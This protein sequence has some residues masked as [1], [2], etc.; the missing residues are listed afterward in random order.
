MKVYPHIPVE[1]YIRQNGSVCLMFLKGRNECIEAVFNGLYNHGMTHNGYSSSPIELD[2][3][4][5][6]ENESMASF[7]STPE[8]IKTFFSSL[9]FH[10]IIGDGSKWKGKKGGIQKECDTYAE[11]QYKLLCEN[12]ALPFNLTSRYSSHIYGE[13]TTTAERPDHDFKD[14]AWKFASRA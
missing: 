11:Q 9:Y 1:L 2:Y 14:E 10:R 5:V 4:E 3:L 13:G 8:K 6:L 7:W 12:F